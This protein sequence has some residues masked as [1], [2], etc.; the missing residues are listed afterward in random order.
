YDRRTPNILDLMQPPPATPAPDPILKLELPTLELSD[1]LL[2]RLSVNAKSSLPSEPAP[3]AGVQ[4][5][6]AATNSLSN[7]NG[8]G[9]HRVSAS[10]P[11]CAGHVMPIR[12]RAAAPAT[13]PPTARA[14]GTARSRAMAEFQ[15]T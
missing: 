10:S 3:A 1:S 14:D 15:H 5:P 7:G 11:S 2:E 6:I 8:N 4:S 13:V 9:K 12:G